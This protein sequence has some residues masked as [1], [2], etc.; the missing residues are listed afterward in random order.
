MP[1]EDETPAEVS[2]EQREHGFFDFTVG[3]THVHIHLRKFGV[4]VP[5]LGLPVGG[6]AMGRAVDTQFPGF[7]TEVC[8]S[9]TERELAAVGKQLELV[10]RQLAAKAEEKAAQDVE[11]ARLEAKLESLERSSARLIAILQSRRSTGDGP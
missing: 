1:E 5:L 10:E 11:T 4:L 2:D 6:A 9:V 3:A 8:T 7:L